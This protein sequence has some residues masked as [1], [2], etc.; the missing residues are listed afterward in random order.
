MRFHCSRSPA[1]HS[2]TATSPT[3][4]NAAPRPGTAGGCASKPAMPPQNCSFGNLSG[5]CGR[6]RFGGGQRKVCSADQPTKM[7][8]ERTKKSTRFFCCCMAGSNAFSFPG[9][10]WERAAAR[11][12][13]ARQSLA[14]T[15]FPARGREPEIG[16]RY[17]GYVSSSGNEEEGERLA[18]FAE[19]VAEEVLQVGDGVD[20]LHGRINVVLDT[21]EF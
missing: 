18:A 17:A 2:A 7:A 3:S 5:G 12:C 4:G 21:A 15:G 14:G 20:L 19:P 13:L 16:V 9:S 10:T 1:D 11:L 8:K 6:T